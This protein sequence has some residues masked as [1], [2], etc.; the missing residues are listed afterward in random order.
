MMRQ[1]KIIFIVLF[2]IQA[3]CSDNSDSEEPLVQDLLTQNWRLV[4]LLINGANQQVTGVSVNFNEDSSF[5]STISELPANDTWVLT[6]GDTRITLNTSNIE[7]S[8]VQIDEEN[9]TLEFITENYKSGTVTYRLE[10]EKT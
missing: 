9:M 1:L 7:I 3:S 8:I 6:N 5:S 4:E 10:F 2:M